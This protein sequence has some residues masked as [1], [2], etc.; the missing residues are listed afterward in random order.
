MASQIIVRFEGVCAHCP[1]RNGLRGGMVGVRVG[2][3]GNSLGCP[4]VETILLVVLFYKL[5]N[6]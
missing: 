6:E 4:R 2:V 5:S 1:L 3:S